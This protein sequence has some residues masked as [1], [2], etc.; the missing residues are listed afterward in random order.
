MNEPEFN[1]HQTMCLFYPWMVMMML[2]RYSAS[3]VPGSLDLQT[4]TVH[5]NL[6]C[7]YSEY[8]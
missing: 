3:Q 7:A 2:S 5:Y 8:F 1:S 6:S 4:L